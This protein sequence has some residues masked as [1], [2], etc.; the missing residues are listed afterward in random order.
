MS[1][2]NLDKAVK[3]F[4]IIFYVCA[5]ALL[6]GMIFYYASVSAFF[7]NLDLEETIENLGKMVSCEIDYKDFHYKG[8]CSK[9]EDIF[10]FL[11]NVSNGE[12]T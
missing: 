6:V 2:T 4:R 8:L 7:G 3:I 1:E 10:N 9:K 5:A 12:S 11:L